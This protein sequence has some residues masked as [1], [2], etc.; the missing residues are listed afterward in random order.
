MLYCRVLL[1]EN[2]LDILN[3]LIFK[4]ESIN[5]PTVKKV[6]ELLRSV[7]KCKSEYSYTSIIGRKQ[8]IDI[9]RSLLLE[10]FA[11]LNYN[12]VIPNPLIYEDTSYQINTM[13]RSSDWNN[14]LRHL[15]ILQPLISLFS[16]NFPFVQTLKHF[17]IEKYGE[18]GVCNDILALLDE[19]RF[20]FQENL[21]ST[22]EVNDEV[23]NPFQLEVIQKAESIKREL[24]NIIFEKIDTTIEEEVC[25]KDKD[26]LH[27]I[28]DIP[29]AIK[30]WS[31]SY[32]FFL[33]PYNIQNSEEPEF[34]INKMAAG[35][36]QYVS[37]FIDLCDIPEGIKYTD[38]IR[39]VYNRILYEGHEFAE[40]SGV[41]GF[42]GNIHSPMAPY[43]II[44]PGMVPNSNFE[45]SLKIEDLSI[46]YLAEED[47]LIFKTKKNDATIHPLYLGFLTWY[48]LP[49][50]Y[51][52][53]FFMVPSNYMS[54]PIA[55][56]YFFQQEKAKKQVVVKIPRIKINNLVIT[57]KQ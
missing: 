36:G 25:L 22:D 29:S 12:P 53:L 50:I 47:K 55:K 1:N 44:Y 24:L 30:N 33:Q 28:D 21:Q 48:L 51:R 27:I 54:L 42:N 4:L 10:I 23:F 26:F 35:Y 3:D 39:E 15:S 49:P 8:M 31:Y 46:H 45:E 16:I 34:V 9:M 20:F 41:F 7:D 37:R 32:S 17:F 11:I 14:T 56:L 2:S 38:M 43:E 40:I 13:L 57:Q 18:T 19:Y 5:H 52:L 6:T